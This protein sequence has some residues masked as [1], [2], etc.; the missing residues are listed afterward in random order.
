[1]LWPLHH[2]WPLIPAFRKISAT[3]V[4]SSPCFRTN[5]ICLSVNFDVFIENPFSPAMPQITDF[6]RAFSHLR[7][8]EGIPFRREQ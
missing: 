2:H 6:S 8:S 3:A 1:M 5:A 7:E 4:P